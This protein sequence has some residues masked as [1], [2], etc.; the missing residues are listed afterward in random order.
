[1]NALSVS[2][3]TLRADFK[4]R[5]I[6][7]GDPGYDIARTVFPGNIDRKPAVIIRAADASDVSRAIALARE[8]GLLLAVR[9]GGHSPAGYGVVNDGIVLDLRD[10][11][12]IDIDSKNNTA[13]AQTGLTA[14]E[15]TVVTDKFGLATGFGDTGTVGIGGIT[16]GGGIGYFVRKY[17]LTIDDVLAAEIVTADGEVVQTDEKNSPDLF[18]A[19]RG[20]GGNF[21]V[22]TKIKY[23]LHPVDKILGGMLM[24]PATVETIDSFMKLAQNAPEE[25][26][27]IVNIM[28]APPMP[29]IPKEYI[30]K[31]VI[32]ILLAH[33]GDIQSGE[34]VM[35]QIRRIVTPIVD[36]VR[37][38]RY[39]ELYPSQSE[40]Y[41][42]VSIG[43]SMFIDYMDV[44]VAKLILE[45]IR[46]STASMAV[47]QLRVLGGAMAR[48][49]VNS[50]AFYHRKSK[51]MVNLAAVY[52]K[53]DERPVH[54]LWITEFES[55]LR[56]SDT[57][58]YVNFLAGVGEKEIRLAYPGATW[59][60]L[61]DIK[62]KYDPTN[63]FRLNQN[64]PPRNSSI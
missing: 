24:L 15:Y 56:Q 63:V 30:G 62:T 22:V 53:S 11:K 26:N 27:A 16:L 48:V 36:T 34:N 31:P 60:K 38:M 21:G 18:W 61:R 43:R 47:A 9:S 57:G 54:E 3:A 5:I 10:M 55:S 4:G 42:P 59:E 25:F 64:I 14:A 39:L 46:I 12:I 7:H 41:H 32:M 8:T 58:A 50:T 45:Q 51:I 28:T 2:T 40:E 35:S 49:D 37:T 6:G 44:N 13:W 29:F 20:G 1:M 17:G 19:I 33:V 23:R 52:Q